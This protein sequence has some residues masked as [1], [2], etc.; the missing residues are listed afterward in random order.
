MV[1]EAE[2][3]MTGAP[4]CGERIAKCNQLMRI[5]EELGGESRLAAETFRKAGGFRHA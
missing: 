1:T 3:I 4:C 2:Q 5:E